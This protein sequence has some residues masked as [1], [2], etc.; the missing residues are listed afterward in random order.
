MDRQPPQD[1]ALDR[2]I[3]GPLQPT[4]NTTPDTANPVPTE[5][6]P[7]D[8]T[9]INA[10][11]EQI[12]AASKVYLQLQ[13][14]RAEAGRQDRLMGDE[15]AVFETEVANLRQQI[16][17]CSTQSVIHHSML[18]VAENELGKLGSH[19]AQHQATDRIWTA[20]HENHEKG[21]QAA[22]S[23]AANAAILEF[24]NRA[25]DDLTQL[26]GC[27]TLAITQARAD[28][29]G[30]SRPQVAATIETVAKSNQAHCA[31]EGAYEYSD[32]MYLATAITS[33]TAHQNELAKMCQDDRALRIK[34]HVSLAWATGSLDLLAEKRQLLS[35]FLQ[36]TS[37]VA[38]PVSNSVD[39][40]IQFAYASAKAYADRPRLLELVEAQRELFYSIAALG[41]S[42]DLRKEL[43]RCCFPPEKPQL[44]QDADQGFTDSSSDFT[45]LTE[46]DSTSEPHQGWT[47]YATGLV[48][49]D[50]AESVDTDEGIDTDEL[51]QQMQHLLLPGSAW[52]ATPNGLP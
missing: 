3:N 15:M 42:L 25:S 40:L 31:K 13:A 46:S 17:R 34:A 9:A 39:D 47:D 29:L 26:P 45:L 27:V 28:Y 49:S 38:E 19:F 7:D 33:A 35:D 52:D 21:L 2:L 50:S 32:R 22:E 37:E 30:A 43:V 6:R 44:G 14:A 36:N 12:A 18:R 11:T 8:S 24:Q 23:A 16:D 1:S 5:P 20:F 51:N 10:S 48:Y 41:E 4:D